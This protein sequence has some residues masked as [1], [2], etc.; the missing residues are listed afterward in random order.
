MLATIGVSAAGFVVFAIGLAADGPRAYFA[1]LAA[2]SFAV[3]IALG[4]LVLVMIGHLANVTWIVAIRRPIEAVA[5]TLPLFLVLFG[6]IAA[7]APALYPW[8]AR[9]GTPSSFPSF[10]GRTLAC[11][12]IPG[13]LATMLFQ[14]SA[15]QDR[16]PDL[17]WALR[18]RTASAVGAPLVAIAFTVASWEWLMSLEPEWRSTMYA[19][20]VF[21][22][23]FVG[24]LAL[25]IVAVFLARPARI[26]ASHFHALGKL[27][28]AMLVFWAYAGYFQGMLIWIANK[29]D[30]VSWYVRR[31]QGGWAPVFYFIVFG[32]FAAPFLLLLSRSLKRRPGALAAVAAFLV[33][34]HYVD[35]YWLVLP[36]HDAGGPAPR[37][38]DLG[39]AL[40]VGGAVAAA[41]VALVRGREA[42]PVLDPRFEASLEY[43]TA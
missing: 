40:G 8:L 24:A 30:D 4:S 34:A 35:V 7:G 32:H 37:W 14:C 42:A 3:T 17:R 13:A 20:Y 39:A 29:P 5:A 12:A 6:P 28:L 41:A 33:L 10:I 2:F 23:G 38:V 19:V 31:A 26:G 15:R 9:P 22:G 1:Y 25:A 16:D 43:R 27:T 21:A 18:A 11:L 36:V